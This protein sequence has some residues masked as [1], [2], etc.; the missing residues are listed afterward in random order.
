LQ[1]FV[2]YLRSVHLHKDK[3]IFKIDQ[4]PV[5]KFAE[6]L[7]L[8][9]TP[10]IKFLNKAI[11]KQRKNA[12]RAVQ[13]SEA[14]EEK[15]NT[16]LF[17][18]ISDEESIGNDSSNES[19]DG[20]AMDKKATDVTKVRTKY[21]RMFQRKNQGVLSEHYNRLI[22]EDDDQ[23]AHS[24]GSDDFLQLKR[25]DHDLDLPAPSTSTT[26]PVPLSQDI[27][28]LSKRKLK[29]PR[30][31]R[32]IVKYGMNTKLV[33]DDSGKAHGL[34]EM[35]DPD[36][37]Y[38]DKGGLEGAYEA[39]KEYTEV[40]REKMRVADV[41]DREVAREKKRE[42]KRKRK[43]REKEV[44][45]LRHFVLHFH[46]HHIHKMQAAGSGA[47]VLP[48][49]ADSDDDDGYVSPEF[50]LP[51]SSESE[52]CRPPSKKLRLGKNKARYTNSNDDLDD[53]EALALKLLGRV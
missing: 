24:E 23:G 30:T 26:P 44:R 41:K 49:V 17:P 22:E 13:E 38:K 47:T 42:K 15:E 36:A 27:S 11:A 29:L 18:E 48:E 34:Y 45:F 35:T 12:S 4:L 14:E 43:E 9:G 19:D 10:K 25:A 39:G 52:D 6:S 5:D 7:G 51:Q 31:K 50:D 33:F 32:A 53:D 2:S 8:P 20:S 1:A 46:T 21:D 16:T 3:N 37:W 28:E 40:E